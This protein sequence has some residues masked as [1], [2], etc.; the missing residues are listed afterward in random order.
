M[1]TFTALYDKR[2][3]AEAVQDRLEELGIVE[4]DRGV[5]DQDATAFAD[6]RGVTPPHEDQHLYKEAVRRGGFLLTVNSDDE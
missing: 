4:L 6:G 1:H 3:D 5:H 2:A